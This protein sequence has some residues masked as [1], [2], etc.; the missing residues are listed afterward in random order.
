MSCYE[1]KSSAIRNDEH[2]YEE[3]IAIT[4]FDNVITVVQVELLKEVLKHNFSVIIIILNTSGGRMKSTLEI[5]RLIRDS[6]IP[7]IVYV[8]PEKATAL[9][10]GT[11]ILLSAH[12]ASMAPGAIIGACHP[13]Y[14]SEKY[15]YVMNRNIVEELKSTLFTEATKFG[16]NLTL[17]NYFIER[18]L[19]VTAEE[20]YKNRVIE[21]LA[22][23]LEDLL[24]KLNGLKIKMKEKVVIL[25]TI[26]KR[27]IFWKPS[28]RIRIL[29][30]L[31]DNIT[32]SL[33]FIL[34][35]IM[36][37]LGEKRS[38][39][40]LLSL[41]CFLLGIL[42]LGISYPNF[43]IPYVVFIALIVFNIVILSLRRFH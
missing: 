7:I 10:A 30:F 2:R 6:E 31:T 40:R 16:R 35:V 21:I 38:M 26:N 8:Y 20:A 36:F 39:L 43:F 37:Y 27:L 34:G 23:T 14:F 18:D 4:R 28:V 29:M 22:P 24:R 41:P 32:I 3:Y 9:S 11:Y 19:V 42:G 13:T 12:I 15:E 5:I 33:A 25:N 17:I 1:N